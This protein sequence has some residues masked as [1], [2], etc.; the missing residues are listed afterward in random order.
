M[1]SLISETL[2][3]WVA[4]FLFV[5]QTPGGFIS[6]YDKITVGYTCIPV[7]VVIDPVTMWCIRL[8]SNQ[9]SKHLFPD[10]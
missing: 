1:P 7:H 5:V 3:H 8:Y 6:T 9:K 2:L 10:S 4:V